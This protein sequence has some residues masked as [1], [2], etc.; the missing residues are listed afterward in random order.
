[1][2]VLEFGRV[3]KIDNSQILMAVFDPAGE[4]DSGNV[5][6]FTVYSVREARHVDACVGC[7]DR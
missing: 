2:V 6:V 7:G 4:L 1:M 3:A 5:I